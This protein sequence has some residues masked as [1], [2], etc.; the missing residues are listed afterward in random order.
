MAEDGIVGEYNGSQAR[1]VLYSWEQWQAL[2]D[3][4]DAEIATASSDADD[5]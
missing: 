3:G 4:R 1:E 2:K 5:G